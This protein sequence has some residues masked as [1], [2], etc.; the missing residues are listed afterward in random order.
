M[1]PAISDTNSFAKILSVMAEDV[2]EGRKENTVFS[3]SEP[4]LVQ[5]I[6]IQ[7]LRLS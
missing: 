2:A 1:K 4:G 3:L 6:G 7:G 5:H